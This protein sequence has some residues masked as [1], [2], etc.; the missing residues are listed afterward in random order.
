MTTKAEI[1]IELLHLAAA[2]EQIVEQSTE[3]KLERLTLRERELQWEMSEVNRQE[4]TVR[5][6]S[7]PSSKEQKLSAAIVDSMTQERFLITELGGIL[8]QKFVRADAM[9]HFHADLAA[10]KKD[11]DKALLPFR[12]SETATPGPRLLALQQELEIMQTEWK[13]KT[14]KACKVGENIFKLR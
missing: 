13:G 10:K 2:R 6:K 4:S 11:V 12:N 1:K 3:K 5:S 7:K 8:P 14:Q 9:L